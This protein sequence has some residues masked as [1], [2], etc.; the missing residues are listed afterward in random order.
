MSVLLQDCTAC[1]RETTTIYMYFAH[2]QTDAAVPAKILKQAKNGGEG[3]C[4]PGRGK[5]LPRQ[6][7]SLSPKALHTC[8]VEQRKIYKD[9][10]RCCQKNGEDSKLGSQGSL[11]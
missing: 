1:L 8:N 2:H 9:K 6:K 3:Y 11:I 7:P 4:K 10:L 5:V